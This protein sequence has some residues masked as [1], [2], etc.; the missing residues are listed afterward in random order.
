MT[1]AKQDS[2]IETPPI[3]LLN[4]PLGK[5]VRPLLN[6]D[7]KTYSP[8]SIS[9]M[10]ARWHFANPDITAEAISRFNAGHVSGCPFS[11]SGT[12]V[13]DK[14]GTYAPTLHLGTT[15]VYTKYGLIDEEQWNKLVSFLCPNGEKRVYLKKLLEYL[16]IRAEQ[17][18]QE[19]DTG[20]NTNG[21]FS[22]KKIQCTAAAE[23][24]KQAFE[25]LALNPGEKELYTN[26]EKLRAFFEDMNKAFTSPAFDGDS[27]FEDED[28]RDTKSKIS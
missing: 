10:L 3:D 27:F 12:F 4:T 17:D 18:P 25:G 1:Q 24:W 26:K 28:K 15:R 21:F 11:R 7:G 2:A 6:A 16:Q 9:A 5:H 20:R 13:P 19:L 8:S 14:D 23:S 22:S